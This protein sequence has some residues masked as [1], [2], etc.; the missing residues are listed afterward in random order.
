[1]YNGPERRKGMNHVKGYS[2]QEL[3]SEVKLAAM[4]IAFLTFTIGGALCLTFD[5]LMNWLG[6]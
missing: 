3:E 4:L 6:L 2:R 1:M 5:G